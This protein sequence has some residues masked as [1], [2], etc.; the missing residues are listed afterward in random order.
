MLTITYHGSDAFSNAD[1]DARDLLEQGCT[2][3][4]LVG[5]TLVDQRATDDVCMELAAFVAEGRLLAEPNTQFVEDGQ[6]IRRR[7]AGDPARPRA[8]SSFRPSGLSIFLPLLVFC[9]SVRLVGDSMLAL[10]GR[11]R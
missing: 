6:S 3:R 5:D 2:V 1:G 11:H 8:F 9:F 10:G 4:L 7:V